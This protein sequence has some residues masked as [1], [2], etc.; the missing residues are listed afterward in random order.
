M[1]LKL[2]GSILTA[3]LLAACAREQANSDGNGTG[4]ADGAGGRQDPPAT[5]ANAPPSSDQT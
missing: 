4:N 1:K 2:V 5:P 3:L